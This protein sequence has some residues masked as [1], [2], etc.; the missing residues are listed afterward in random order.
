MKSGNRCYTRA[1]YPVTSHSNSYSYSPI[2]AAAAADADDDRPIV[3]M[4]MILPSSLA[5]S[6]QAVA[7][8]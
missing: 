6:L 4:T 1:R 7:Y 2:A 8:L 3:A 5:S